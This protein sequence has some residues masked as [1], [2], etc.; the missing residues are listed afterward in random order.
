LVISI[1]QC[2]IIVHNGHMYEMFGVC[3]HVSV[4]RYKS[5]CGAECFK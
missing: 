1:Y 2:V 5:W 3:W 4:N